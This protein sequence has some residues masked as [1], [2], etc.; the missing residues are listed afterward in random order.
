MVHF[1]FQCQVIVVNSWS[2]ERLYD[3]MRAPHHTRLL[4]MIE[5]TR[6]HPSTWEIAIL[7]LTSL[8]TSSISECFFRSHRIT[9]EHQNWKY[10]DL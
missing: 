6:Q 3:E 9:L 8:N 1:L 2:Q 7:V 5:L 4:E 10:I